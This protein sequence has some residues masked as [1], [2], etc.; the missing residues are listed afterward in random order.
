V[1]HTLSI[2]NKRSWH[3]LFAVGLGTIMVP[4]NASIVNV[5]LPIITEFFGA[6]VATSE[7]VL[8]SYLITLLSFVLFFGKFGDF[9]GHERLYMVGL[10]GF[11][12]S[13]LLCSLAPSILF[14][15]FLRAIQGFTAAM[16]LS[17]SL[18]L[19]KKSFPKSMLGQALGIYAV[20]IAGGLTLGPAIGGI[21]DGLLG[22]RSIFL[23]NLPTAIISLIICYKI[24]DRGE[25]QK[26]KWDI[27][28][29]IS[30]FLALFSLVY[31]LNY[32]TSNPINLEAIILI[33]FTISMTILFIWWERHTEDPIL[34]LSLF[35][36]I[37]F[38]AYNLSLHLNYVCMYMIIFVMPFYLLKVL[39]LSSN[40]TGLVLTAAPLL[41]M[42]LAPISGI[43]SD[44]FG[45]R[46]LSFLGAMICAV[47]F[48]S[49]TQLTFYSTE[50][51]VF[52]RLALLGVGAA[53]FQS[54]TNRAIMSKIPNG[55]AGVASGIL[56]TMRN[57]GMVFAVC[58]AGILLSTTINPTTLQLNTLIP[59]QAYDLT[60]GMHLV[61]I[62]G[63]FLSL[64]MALLSV[65]GILTGKI[66]KREILDR[67]QKD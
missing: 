36:D 6:T 2:S 41:M 17:V 3:I 8:T 18:G 61:V 32:I 51:D 40:T 27:I 20:V 47:A 38:S 11:I 15:I 10:V 64:I 60:T 45:S 53:I 67:V 16:M 34:D 26:I 57:L 23:I 63:A 19:V 31:L 59:L 12:F 49:M 21:L 22:W 50:I 35:R 28:G 4:I 54:P 14:L 29:T 43:I 24:L 7:W 58:Y 39:N 65:I 42:F 25:S 33:L 30:Q 5:S 13:S 46:P 52:L 44:R 56:V 55:Q 1:A 66:I 37:S 9:W 48:F 62:L